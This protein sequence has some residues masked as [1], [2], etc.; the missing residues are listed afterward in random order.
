MTSCINVDAGVFTALIGHKPTDWVS[1]N[2]IENGWWRSEVVPAS[3]IPTLAS[4]YAE[5]DCWIGV[6][7]VRPVNRGRGGNADVVRLNAVVAEIDHDKCP[8]AVARVIVANLTGA[9]GVAPTVIVNSG[10]GEHVWFPID[11]G[12]AAGL[13]NAAAAALG[14]RFGM[15][16]AA[17]AGRHKVVVDNVDDL[18]RVLR[19]PGSMN[20]KREPAVPVVGR[21]NQHGRPITVDELTKALDR[22]GVAN[23]TASEATRV[24]VAPP[25]TWSYDPGLVEYPC[26][27]L[28]MIRIGWFVD[29]PRGSRHNWLLYQG[30]RLHCCV[31]R[32]CVGSSELYWA[33]RG[34]LRAAFHHRLAGSH[35]GT[36]RAPDP[37]NEFESCLAYS[38]MR[39]SIKTGAE[40]LG[41]TG[42]QHAHDQTAVAP[43]SLAAETQRGEGE[44]T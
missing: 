9:L 40:V 23:V 21:W 7:P 15:L 14:R 18:A 44:T 1:F 33:Y 39:A 31:R 36:P 20:R 10:H 6:N 29:P 42:G 35:G 32:G 34:E 4:A 26:R 8:P 30:A 43:T 16:V 24:V 25:S 2:R 41:E 27:Y 38:V 11:R 28:T 37:A 12:S 3:A 19:I 5:L 17:V 13:S 22:R